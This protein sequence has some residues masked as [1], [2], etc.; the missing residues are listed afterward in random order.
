[1]FEAIEADDTLIVE[2][3][4]VYLPSSFFEQPSERGDVY[5]IPLDLFSSALRF[6]ERSASVE[7]LVEAR[8]QRTIKRSKRESVAFRSWIR[9]EIDKAKATFP[10]DPELQLDRRSDSNRNDHS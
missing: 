1:M 10:K 6:R 9:A 7:E 5:R 3:E 8:P 4:D 2:L